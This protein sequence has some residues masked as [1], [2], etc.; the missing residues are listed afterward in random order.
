MEKEIKR[1]ENEIK[2]LRKEIFSLREENKAA[3]KSIYE[4]LKQYLKNG[5]ESEKELVE[6]FREFKNDMAVF[7]NEI[8]KEKPS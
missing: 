2:E 4:V 5:H 1:L 3:E 8:L 6:V 7:L